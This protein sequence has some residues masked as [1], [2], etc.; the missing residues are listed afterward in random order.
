MPH[1]RKAHQRKGPSVSED[2]LDLDEFMDRVQN[3][4]ELLFELLDIFVDDFHA[5]RQLLGEAVEKKDYEAVEH[6]AHFLKGSCG[7]ISAKI[8]WAVF[9]E[10]EEKGRANDLEGAGKYLSDID[11]GFEA[12]VLRIGEVRARLA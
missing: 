10:L 11:Q 8:L 7:N 4:T 2:T 5:K 12:L 6:V 1:W 9:R 3:D